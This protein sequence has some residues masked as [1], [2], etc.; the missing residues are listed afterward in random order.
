MARVH[1]KEPDLTDP[2]CDTPIDPTKDFHKALGAILAVP[3]AEVDQHIK[4]NPDPLQKHGYRRVKN[5]LSDNA[6]ETH[7]E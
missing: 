2:L 4:D 1:K 6:Q 3:R 5:K 7:S